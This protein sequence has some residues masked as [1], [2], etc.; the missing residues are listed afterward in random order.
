MF[1][2]KHVCFSGAACFLRK[3]ETVALRQVKQ[4]HGLNRRYLAP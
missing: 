2:E 4:K 3:R 1:R